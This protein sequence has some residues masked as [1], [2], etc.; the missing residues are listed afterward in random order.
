MTVTNESFICQNCKTPLGSQ[1]LLL[2]VKLG[3]EPTCQECGDIHF[4][5]FY[6]LPFYDSV[7]LHT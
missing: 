2:W 4:D 3:Q 5:F 7:P 1:A 6:P